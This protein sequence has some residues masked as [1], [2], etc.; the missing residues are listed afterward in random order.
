MISFKNMRLAPKIA[1]P[2][3]VML[4]V[5]LGSL[6]WI[7]QDRS[8]DVIRGIA[9]KEL[10]ALAGRYAADVQGFIEISL[11]ES[12]SLAYILQDA[13]QDQTGMTREEVANLFRSSVKKNELLIGG[14]CVW[15]PNAFDGKDAEYATQEPY[16]PNGTFSLYIANSGG[17]LTMASLSDDGE[18]YQGPKR[19]GKPYVTDPYEFDVNGQRVP[20]VTGSV[21]IM[22]NGRFIGIASTDITV[23][24]MTRKL[25]GIQVYGTGFASLLNHDG[26]VIT[27]PNPSRINVNLFQDSQVKISDPGAL[28]EAMRQG[29]PY[30]DVRI[31]NGEKMLCYYQP[32]TFRN[33]GISW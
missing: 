21:P 18:Y 10:S 19:T 33:T 16:K 32:I 26:L 3:S 14:G 29:R 12:T 25:N 8:S 17:R 31:I 9:H 24:T 5:C 6:A 28:K 7:I 13:V 11:N 27:H 20:M 22:V 30:N 23:E 2:V 4:I 1:L 15:L